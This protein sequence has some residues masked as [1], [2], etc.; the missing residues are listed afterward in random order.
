[1]DNNKMFELME[2]MYIEMK[3]M[4]QEMKNG[5]EE[6]KEERQQLANN[7]VK[8]EDDI[9]KLQTVDEGI[10]ANTQKLDII[11]KKVDNIE[12][13]IKEKSIVVSKDYYIQLLKKA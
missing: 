7:I 4:K 8:I 3:N 2:K 10:L 13:F 12:E 5:F 1:M 9:S 6:A 11:E